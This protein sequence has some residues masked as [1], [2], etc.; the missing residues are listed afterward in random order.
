MNDRRATMKEISEG[1]GG[2]AVLLVFAFVVVFF[3]FAVR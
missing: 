2:A 1:A 3:V